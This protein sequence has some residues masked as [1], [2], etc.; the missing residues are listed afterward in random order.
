M[1]RIRLLTLPLAASLLLVLASCSKST[2]ADAAKPTA[3]AEH[4]EGEA[5][6]AEGG[7][8]EAAGPVKM[9][10]ASMKAA[11]IRL[12]TLQPSSLSEELRAPGEVVDSA[13]GTTL[14][15]PQVEAL[16]VRRHAKL[17]DEVR[18]G[19]PLATLASVEVSDA[20]AELR[21]AEQEWRRVSALGREAVAG[22]RINEAKVAV[23]RARAKAQAYGLPGTASGGVNGQFTLTAPHAGRI[24]EDEFVVGERIEPGKPLFRLVDESVVWVDAKLPS[25]TVSRI[26]PGSSATIVVQGERISG[27]VLRSAHRTS[28]A[29]RTASVRLEVPNKGDRLHGGDFV[30][31][32]FEAASGANS[33]NKAATQLAI[34]TDA[35]VQLEGETVVFRRNAEGA[36]EPVPVRTGE[37]IGDRTVIREGLKAGDSVV[38]AGA[39]AVKSQILKAQLG[40][41]HGH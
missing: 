37:V 30:E 6:H 18:A 8:E 17:G 12:Q 5:D 2:D 24:T 27:K 23:D 11:G 13:Y 15:T 10:E 19:A 20:Q 28:D 40:E 41:G 36:L 39:F 29:T 26:E 16:V 9:D 34:P 21:I 25:G 4:A 3:E 1:D 14:I 22:R 31:V 32:Y 7:E 35:L 33:D 38:V